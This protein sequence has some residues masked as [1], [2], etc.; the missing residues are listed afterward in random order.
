[1]IR[2]FVLFLKVILWEEKKII[3]ICFRSMI[4]YLKLI[5]IRMNCLKKIFNYWLF[6][7]LSLE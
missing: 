4:D 1:M 6:F 2:F 5:G 3:I 7:R